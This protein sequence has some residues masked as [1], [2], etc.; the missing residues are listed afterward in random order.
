[1]YAIVESRKFAPINPFSPRRESNSYIILATPTLE[2]LRIVKPSRLTL[3]SLSAL[4]APA[5]LADLTADQTPFHTFRG[6]WVSRF[7]YSVSSAQSSISAIM[8]NAKALNFTDIM[9]QVRG[10]ADAYYYLNNGLEPRATGVTAA[11]D[12]L[13]IAVNEAHSRGLKLHV[14][15]NTMPLWSARQTG[16]NTADYTPQAPASHP[17]NT[18]PNFWIRDSVNKP[19]P[20]PT[21]SSG[22]ITVNP[23]RTDVQNHI[24]NVVDAI[25]SNYA[26]DGLHLDYIRL[27][28]NTAGANTIMQ[29]P[30]DPDTVALFQQ[31][32]PGETPTSHPAH[33]KTFIADQITTLVSGIRQTL[34]TERPSAQLTG[35]VWRDADI[36]LDSYQQ[37]WSRWIDSGLLDAAMPMI[38]RKGF[39]TGGTNMDADSGDLYRLNVTEALDRRG[40]AA[41]MPG[42]GTYMQDS[43]ATAYNNTINQLIYAR[44]KGANGVQIY[45]SGTLFDGSAA[46]NEVK[47]ALGDFFS[48]NSGAPATQTITNFDTS[49][50]HFGFSPTAS[51]QTAGVASATAD[52]VTSE[53]HAGAGSQRLIINKATNASSF[54]IRHLSGAP[55]GTGADPASNTPYASLGTIGLW[56]KTSTPDLQISIAT[57][58]AADLA[59]P[60]TRATGDRSFFKNIIPDNQ[61]HQYEWSLADPG[62]W[63]AWVGSGNGHLSTIFSLD[64]IFLTGTSAANTLYLDDVFYNPAA[65]APNQWTRD[66]DATWSHAGNWTGG[67]PNAIGATAKLL[68]RT[69]APRTLTLDAPVTLGALNIDHATAYTLAGT[70][71]LTL[72]V[73]TGSASINLINRG[74]HTIATPLHFN[75][76]SILNIDRGSTLTLANALSNPVGRALVKSDDGALDIS[77]QQ[78]HGP[79][80]SFTANA[81][82]TTFRTSGGSNLAVIV[83]AASLTFDANQTLASLTLNTTASAALTLGRKSLLVRSL[84]MSA[85]ATLDLVDGALAV[86]YIAANPYGD[87]RAAILQAYNPTNSAHWLDPGLTSSTA[88]T[89]PNLL[90]GYGQASTLLA[91]SGTA[92]ATW[93]SQ[94]VD[95]TTVLVRV[96]LAGDANLDGAVNFLDLTALA[97]AYGTPGD[98]AQGDFNY[99]GTVNFLDLTALA[100]QYGSALPADIPLAFASVPEPTTLFPAT[101]LC[102]LARRR[103]QRVC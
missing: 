46:Q 33:F 51:A 102:L 18:N 56:I 52:R 86:D 10:Q 63:D 64:S 71:T 7:D 82:A 54:T 39:G 5:A 29:Y 92:T 48:A 15:F 80:A 9:F 3:L 22:Y 68:R 37:D 30:R 13:A 26:I 41:I 77:G 17:I 44:D 12:P 85:G 36:G 74:A 91:L 65:I 6:L 35:S 98:W 58:D 19:Q 28:N 11:N 72:S 78:S 66:A 32:Y 8:T 101:A 21:G 24:R 2:R 16:T 93:Q 50:G 83:N 25:A 34:K 4:G 75:S 49:E 73:S 45:N 79:G 27:T 70:N 57:D 55:G 31:V 23:T 47:R 60:D 100:A 69:T 87:I 40:A 88:R 20:F 67:V 59:D 42:L 1:M 81:G 62:V 43:A 14:W 97:A 99:D 89:N 95:A 96:T 90:L 53:A 38:Y 61:W 76:N 84:A 103:R 94:T